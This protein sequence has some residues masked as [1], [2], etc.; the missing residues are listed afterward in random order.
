MLIGTALVFATGAVQAAVFF[1][2]PK[3]LAF[4]ATSDGGRLRE[5]HVLVSMMIIIRRMMMR[6]TRRMTLFGDL[7]PQPIRRFTTQSC[8]I[9]R[10]I[11]T[12]MIRSCGQCTQ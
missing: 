8:P 10:H 6:R 4:L 3:G 1:E 2:K 11:Y 5:T 9:S 12:Y 7:Q